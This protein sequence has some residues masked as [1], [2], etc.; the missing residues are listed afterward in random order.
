MRILVDE[1]VPVQI[2]PLLTAAGHEAAH[3]DQLGLKGIG[4]GALLSRAVDDG[5]EVL[6]TGDTKMGGTQNIAA[7]DVAVVVIRG[8][9]T[10]KRLP[11]LMP[12]ILATLTSAARRAITEV[13]RGSTEPSTPRPASTPREDLR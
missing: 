6:L 2:V 13:A 10:P 9:R 7:Y 11:A 8:R 1:N 12:A 3:V 4:N 5:Y